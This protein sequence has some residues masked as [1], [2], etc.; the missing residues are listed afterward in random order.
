MAA[1]ECLARQ[2]M[3]LNVSLPFN[4]S[5]NVTIFLAQKREEWMNMAP[6]NWPYSTAFK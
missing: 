6:A 1:D 2:A 5:M 4:F 3:K